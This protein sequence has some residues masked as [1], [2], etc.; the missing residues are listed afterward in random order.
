[1][2]IQEDTHAKTEVHCLAAAQELLDIVAVQQLILKERSARDMQEWELLASCFTED[3]V[4]EMSWFRGTGALFAAESKKI[5]AG[6]LLTF[7]ET[8]PSSIQI[9]K[10][11]AIADTP[12]AAH[13]IREMGGA[14]VDITFWT[15]MRSRAERRSG[16]WL[17]S[18]LRIIYLHDLIVARMPASIPNLNT[19]LLQTFRPTYRY[20]SYALSTSGHP[21]ANDLPGIDQPETVH[22]LITAEEAWL[23]DPFA[24][25]LRG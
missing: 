21:I 15:R 2:P 14:D 13:V 9:C 1:M 22:R 25:S 4:I 20:L 19:D 8:G 6:G 3:S 23:Y 16:V 5:A 18:G 17:L 10:D 24:A 7:H 12:M 11:R